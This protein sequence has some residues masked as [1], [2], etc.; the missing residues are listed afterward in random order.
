MPVAR[1]ALLV[2]VVLSAAALFAGIAPAARAPHLRAPGPGPQGRPAGFEVVLENARC[3]GCHAEIAEEWRSSLHRASSEDPIFRKAYSVEPAGFCVDCH[4]P[5][6]VASVGTACVTCHVVDGH[7]VGARA[8]AADGGVHAV[9][10][11][12][13]MRTPAACASC[14]QFDFPGRKTPMQD[15][16]RE[17]ARSS[18]SAESC[19]SCHMPRVAG[20]DGRAHARHDFHVIGDPDMLRRAVAVSAAAGPTE[21]EVVVTLVPAAVGHAFPT[22]DMFRRLEVRA[23]AVDARGEVTQVGKSVPLGRVF[24]AEDEGGAHTGRRQ[25]ADRRV[26]PP[27]EGA[28]RKAIVRFPKAIGA[29]RVSWLVAY[30]RMDDD[31]ARV[32]G[33]EPRKD[34]TVI[35]RGE[36]PPRREPKEPS[37]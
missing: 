33:L 28:E 27:G 1:R 3:E 6:G 19:Q 37:R 14:H 4:E 36:L 5:E 9:R 32:F 11:A 7:V 25:I 31:M 21:D 35:A 16:V 26:P 29:D 20:A 34:E 13:W 23:S 12:P 10:A 15:T 17:H 8:R 18:R 24:S 2:S 30:Q 22:G